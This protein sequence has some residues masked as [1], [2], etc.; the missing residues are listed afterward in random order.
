MWKAVNCGNYEYTFLP[1]YEAVHIIE[2]KVL[3]KRFLLFLYCGN[4]E[5]T[6]M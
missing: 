4:Y 5:W 2:T 3:Q 1:I 6:N